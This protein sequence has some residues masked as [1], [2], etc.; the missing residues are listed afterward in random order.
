MINK[1]FKGNI[2]ETDL[3]NLNLQ[4]R[5]IFETDNIETT[6]HSSFCTLPVNTDRD[7]FSIKPWPLLAK[8]L[9]S[10]GLWLVYS[11]GSL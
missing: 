2:N 4:D 1:S 8:M 3:T 11:S 5:Q 9:G 7:L 10:L 6:L